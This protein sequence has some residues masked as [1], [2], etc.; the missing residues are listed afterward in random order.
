M[1][2]F[3]RFGVVLVTL[4][5][6]FL[7]MDFAYAGYPMISGI[8]DQEILVNTSTPAIPF[9]LYDDVTNPSNLVL[10]Y[11]S[12]NKDLVPEDDDNIIFGGS[13]ST[14]T[15]RVIPAPNK[16]GLA[17]ITVI[18]ADSNGDTNQDDFSVEVSR[19]PQ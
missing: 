10:S 4:I 7:L 12:N 14:R 19:P 11:T 2:N 9:Y 8:T 16:T 5:S 1:K 3:T 15:V 18:V 13:G 6:L 17:I